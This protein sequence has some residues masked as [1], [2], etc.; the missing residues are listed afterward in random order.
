VGFDR[1]LLHEREELVLDLRPHWWFMFEPSGLLLSAAV[2]GLLL[3]VFVDG[4]DWV[5]YAAVALIVGALAWFGIRYAKWVT[6]NFVVTSDRVV[7]RSG[8]IAKKGI[9]IPLERVN[10]VFFSQGIFER[11]LGAGDLSIESGGE[12]GKQTFSD[13][14]RP[15]AV[16]NE[17]Y[18]QMELNNT[19]MYGGGAPAPAPQPAAPS[20]PDQIAQLDALR[21]QGALSEAEFAEK[22]AELLKRM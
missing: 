21:Q 5:K 1:R 13:V 6:T 4:W 15:S 9:E 20:I 2:V 11:M 10:T 3:V 8:V 18:R 16:Q 22:K 17:I 14:R 12:T 19:R 7:Y